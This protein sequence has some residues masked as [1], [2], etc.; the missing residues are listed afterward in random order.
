MVVVLTNLAHM[1]GLTIEECIH[2]AYEVINK[3]TGKMIDGTF[4]KDKELPQ[5]SMTQ[6]IPIKYMKL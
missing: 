6:N 5:E 3:R 4:V 1:R 2:S